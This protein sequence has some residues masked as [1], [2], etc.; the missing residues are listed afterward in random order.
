MAKSPINYE[1]NVTNSQNTVKT[2]FGE[3]KQ[4]YFGSVYTEG[5][6]SN[7]DTQKYPVGANIYMTFKADPAKVDNARQFG[8][9]NQAY[10]TIKSTSTSPVQ[11]YLAEP[12][13]KDFATTD[14]TVIDQFPGMN[15]PLYA[16]DTKSKKGEGNDIA[17][18][19]TK[20]PVHHAKKHGAETVSGIIK[21]RKW[22]GHGEFGKEYKEGSKPVSKAATFQDTPHNLEY[23]TYHT[24]ENNFESAILSFSGSDA[25]MYYGSVHWGFKVTEKTEEADPTDPSKKIKKRVIDGTSIELKSGGKPTAAFLKSVKAWNESKTNVAS[26]KDIIQIPDHAAKISVDKTPLFVTEADID[27][28]KSTELSKDTPCMTFESKVLGKDQKSYDRVRVEI[29]GK[30]MMGW[31][32]SSNIIIRQ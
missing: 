20:F 5:V 12:G 18:Y 3:F 24:L 29:G 25:G 31:V 32:P 8:F 1:D 30:A 19:K 4:E 15:N 10:S 2:D 26:R 6:N 16:T 21:N 11:P 14:K 22:A 7:G 9:I 28:A 23:D 27:L 17:G 13:H